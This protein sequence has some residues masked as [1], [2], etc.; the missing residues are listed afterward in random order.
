[1]VDAFAHAPFAYCPF[2]LLIV[3]SILSSL[4][5]HRITQNQ[6]LPQQMG[7]YRP[8]GLVMASHSSSSLSRDQYAFWIY[9][10]CPQVRTVLQSVQLSRPP[11][12]MA[13]QVYVL[14]VDVDGQSRL[15]RLHP[16][17]SILGSGS[18]MARLMHQRS[19]QQSV[20][21]SHALSISPQTASPG[22]SAPSVRE[23]SIHHQTARHVHG[24]SQMLSRAL[25]HNRI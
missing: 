14:L 10:V 1:M 12:I 13:P 23:V 16:I 11:N 2:S 4:S 21:S 6:F 17:H 22:I 15:Q 3:N 18:H 9:D 7:Q 25:S 19:R 20:V 8:Y 5:L 24:A